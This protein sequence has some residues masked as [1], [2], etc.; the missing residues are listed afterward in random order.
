MVFTHDGVSHDGA[1]V[2]IFDAE[3]VDVAGITSS[4]WT[5]I[6]ADMTI[7][8][9]EGNIVYTIN[10]RPATEVMREYL[11]VTDNELLPIVIS[12][13]LQIRRPDGTEVLRAALAM[14][15]EKGALIFAG[16]VPEG[17]LARFSSSFGYQTIEQAMRDMEEF[18]A[19]HPHASQLLL[20]SC[21]ARYRVAGAMA[22]DEV[23]A[24]SRL[25][26]APLTGFFTYGEI[27]LNRLG[28]CDFYNE[29]LSLV[30]IS[31]R[32]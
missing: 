11:D 7:T 19:G 5:G 14:D 1:A 22:A 12:F 17:S 32:K 4:G 6:G 20:F 8:S 28:T 29:T 23:L 25:W 13:P 27:G 10:G 24:A 3:K 26:K 30:L 21:C 9:S 2:L 18:H 16:S 15:A 31:L